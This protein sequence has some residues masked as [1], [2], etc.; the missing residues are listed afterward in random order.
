MTLSTPILQFGTS[1]FLQ[2]HADLFISEAMANGDAL[3]GITVVQT[4][5][6]PTSA[7]RIQAFGD[8]KGYPV[9]IRGVV[10]G[11]P[12]DE[13][14]TGH[15]IKRAL[16]ASQDWAEVRQAFLNAQVILSN[17]SDKGYDL[18]PADSSFP[19]AQTVPRSY[20]AKLVSLLHHRWQVLP[21]APLSLFPCE[22]IP[23]NGDKLLDAVVG[24]ARDWGLHDHFLYYLRET[25]RW[26][27][28]LVDRIVSQ[29]IE[30][31]GAVAE[32]YALWAIEKQSG[33]ILPCAHP[34]IVLTDDLSRFERLKLYLLNLAHT[35]LAEGWLAEQRE[36]DETVLQAMSNPRIR[37]GLESCWMEE[38]MPVLVDQGLGTDAEAYIGHLRDRLLNPFLFHRLRDISQNHAEKKRRRLAPVVDYAQRHGLITRQTRL[39]A[40]LAS[41]LGE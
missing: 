12:F 40:A 41:G 31:I 27:N 16:Q 18:D 4:T 28:S 25:C 29:P 35:M 34:S 36:P 38:V 21:D 23:R 6:S 2:A 1:R 20:P 7:A 37:A 9:R 26:A 17:V 5:D 13:T 33:L 3:G 19:D 39:R 8:P 15:A 30:P 14:R 22:L 32:P 11:R 10:N 24:L